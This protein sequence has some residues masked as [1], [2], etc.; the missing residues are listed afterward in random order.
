MMTHRD[1]AGDRTAHGLQT[2]PMACDALHRIAVPRASGRKPWE[3]V[4]MGHYQRSL[5][6]SSI[7]PAL[8]GAFPGEP[9]PRRDKI[10]EDPA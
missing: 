8:R 3:T 7:L 4:S 5:V 2:G 10:I 6:Q 1:R 9:V